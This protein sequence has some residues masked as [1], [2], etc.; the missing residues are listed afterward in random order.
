[1]VKRKVIVRK[2]DALEALGGV[3]NICSD[4]TGTLT[5]G[6]M[7]TKKVWIPKD[8]MYSVGGVRDPYDH[9]SGAVRL[10][11]A[12]NTQPDTEEEAERKRQERDA[13]RSN[14]G[15][16]F[17]DPVARRKELERKGSEAEREA[18][19]EGESFE[20]YELPEI[21]RGL[22]NLL[23]IAALCNIANVRFDEEKGKW[24]ANG[25]PTE[26]RYIP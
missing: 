22:G 14:L 25:D 19:A 20:N 23:Q 11:P 1:M 21:T 3:T 12:P 4:K 16:T 17:D 10:G 8:G 6:R 26:V 18:E 13:A 2:L 7:I 15:L 24:I 5:Q 9:T